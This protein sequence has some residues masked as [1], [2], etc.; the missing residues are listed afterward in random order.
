M[1]CPENFLNGI[2]KSNGEAGGMSQ[3]LK[4]LVVLV[5]DLDSVSSTYIV[6]HNQL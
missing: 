5:E 2:S 6:A 3:W 4:A 1:G